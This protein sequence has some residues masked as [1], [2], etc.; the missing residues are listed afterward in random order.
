MQEPAPLEDVQAAVDYAVK[1]SRA[2]DR[3]LEGRGISLQGLEV[4]EIG[5]GKDLGP[6]LLMVDKGA[7]V[8]VVDTE[9]AAWDQGFYSALL[10]AVGSSPAVER[11]LD[12][13]SF[14]GILRQVGQSAE[15]MGDIAAESFDLVL[16]NAALEH[17]ADIDAAA[18]EL[19]RVSRAGA[20]HTHQVDF[21]DHRN[22]DRPLEHLLLP[23]GA[24]RSLSRKRIYGSQRR[25]GELIQAF[26]LAGFRLTSLN[27]DIIV[28]PAYLAD[29]IPRLRRAWWSPYRR[30]TDL[31]ILSARLWF[32][33]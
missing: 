31:A 20:I 17:I 8:T 18:S 6:Q 22:F 7:R 33:N 13:R 3:I 11:G 2:Y 15:N 24:F 26:L 30:S 29:F 16:S 9:P 5:P 28:D 23:R 32:T 25:P 10:G 4:L 12:Q 27:A 14:D 19:R 1:V 21:R